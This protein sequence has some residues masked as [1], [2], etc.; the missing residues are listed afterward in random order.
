[1]P[2]SSA[3]LRR[4]LDHVWGKF[5]T[6]PDGTPKIKVHGFGMTRP[7]LMFRYPWHSIDSTTWT[8]TSQYGGLMM[9]FLQSDGSI[10]DFKID[11]SEGS[12]NRRWHYQA[13]K[14][15][16]KRAVNLRLQQMEAERI[17]DPKIE[18]DFKAAMG[19]EMGFNPVALS[20]CY[21]LRAFGN[22]AYYHRVMG[23]AGAG[24]GGATSRT[25]H[26]ANI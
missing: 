6:N 16:D 2:E 25:R 19:C 1:M 26:R 11:F 23:R 8:M 10:I 9:D 18:A 5:L 17:A 14:P 4:W 3:I 24:L 20:K 22:I 13:L 21:G 12:Y 15:A 7:S